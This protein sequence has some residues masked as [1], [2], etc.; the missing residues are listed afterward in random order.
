M[1]SRYLREINDRIEKVEQ[2]QRKPMLEAAEMVA[3]CIEGEGIVYLFGC[4]HSHML[5]EEMFYRAGGLAAVRPILVE[6]L[7]L[8]RGA[9]RSSRMERRT[10]FARSFMEKE[11]IREGD[12]TV[13]ISNSGV[14]PVPVDVALIAKAKGAS[15]IGL[16]SLSHSQN[17]SPKHESGQRLFEVVDLVLDTLVEK[18]DAMMTHDRLSVKFGPSSTIVGACILNA[19]F[20]EAIHRLVERG[21]EPPIFQSGNV[22]GTDDYNARLIQK[23]S[24]RIPI[25][26]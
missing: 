5:A 4:G 12:V 23:Y 24:S 18:G 7:M 25:L 17:T 1:L 11:E 26:S 22:E 13:V 3:R 21:V 8:H 2:E 10:E 15:V 16:T 19:V 14:N 9:G 20:A 6:D